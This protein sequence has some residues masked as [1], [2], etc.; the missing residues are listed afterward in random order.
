MKRPIHA[1]ERTADRRDNLLMNFNT[2]QRSTARCRQRSLSFF[3]LDLM[4]HVITV[5][6]ATGLLTLT[7]AAAQQPVISISSEPTGLTV[8]SQKTGK[9]M[10]PG[11][12]IYSDG[13]VAVRRYAGSQSVKRIDGKTVEQLYQE[14]L[15][16]K[17]YRV[18]EDSFHAELDAAHPAGTTERTTER[19]AITD[20]PIWSLRIQ[21]RD[22][23]RSTKFYGLW[24]MAEYY[25]RNKQLKILRDAILR[26]YAA[27]G[28]KVYE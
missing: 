4:P 5:A 3:S 1:M 8:E 17:F 20:C 11:I 24:D 6:L 21:R 18:T 26:V 19:I 12:D 22:A 7:S 27:V 25:P 10:I 13:R 2:K 15:K 9:K 14:L 16:S 23:V 28:E